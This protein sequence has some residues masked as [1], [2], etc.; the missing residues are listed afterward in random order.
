[1][2]ERM[3]KNLVTGLKNDTGI[4]YYFFDSVRKESLSPCTF[5][6]SILHQLIRI[7]TLNPALQRRIEKVFIG[8]NGSREPEIDE[9]ET[10]AIELCDALKKVIILVDG[11]NEAQ[12]DDQKLTLRFL[13]SIQQSRAVIK[14]FVAIR[15][16]V[17]VPNFFSDGQI[18]HIN[19][20]AN[21]TQLEIDRFTNSRVEKEA[22]DGSL[23]VCEPA[24]IEDIK[25]TLKSKARG[26]YDTHLL[27]NFA[28]YFKA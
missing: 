4:A 13:K 24:M 18:T 2:I 14:L 11:I 10:L 26:M 27:V 23:T 17:A 16:E 12:Q 19:I 9:M 3:T 8:P 6:R 25:K 15:P 22:K 20:R 7:E 28:K 1:M 21:D 5:L